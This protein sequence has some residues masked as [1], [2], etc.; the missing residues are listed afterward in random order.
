MQAMIPA[1]VM[2]DRRQQAAAVA[3]RGEP[4]RIGG[5]IVLASWLVLAAGGVLLARWLLGPG[6]WLL[7][8]RGV[9]D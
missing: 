6:E 5:V 1:A 2:A 4:V 7:G 8:P 3:F 9:K